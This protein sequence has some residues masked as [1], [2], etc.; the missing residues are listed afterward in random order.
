ML[1]GFETAVA[2]TAA[3]GAIRAVS[4]AKNLLIRTL[5]RRKLRKELDFGSSASQTDNFLSALEPEIAQDLIRFAS[6]PELKNLSMNLATDTLLGHFGKGS[7][8][9]SKELKAQLRTL[10]LLDTQLADPDVDAATEIIFAAMSKAVSAITSEL[11][12]EEDRLPATAK[13][14][15]LKVRDSYLDSAV[16]NSALLSTIRDLSV[17]KNFEDQLKVQ[18]RNLYGTMRLPHAGT[19]RRV[20]YEKLYVP[21]RVSF[22]EEGNATSSIAESKIEVEDLIKH[23]L[24]L[25]LLGDPGGGKSTLS[26]K[27]TFDLASNA[28]EANESAVPFL[29]VLREYASE[30]SKRPLSLIEYLEQTC[31]VFFSIEPPPNAL[32]YL[33]LNGRAFVI[34]DGLDELLDTALRRQVVD[35]VTGFAHRYP[36]TSIL[37]TSRRVGY[38][39]APL[40]PD[41]FAAF[42]LREFD[43]QQVAK[44]VKNWFE[45][46]ES[47]QPGRRKDLCQSF[48]RDSEFVT[49]LR[50]NPLM[51]SLMCGIYA[52][53]NYIPRNRPDVYE[54]CALL[55]FDSWDKQRGIKAPLSFDAHV[56]AAMRSLALWLY[57]QQA[58]QQGLPRAKLINYMKDYLIKKRFDNEEEAENAATEFIDFCKGRA[59]VLTDVG[60]ELYGFTHRTF[61]EYFAASQIVRENTD[62]AR[63]FDYL[64]ERLSGGGWEVVA[65]LALQVLNKS[66]E[67][68][69]DDFLEILLAHTASDI[70]LPL[71]QKLLTFAAQALT[72]IVPRPP[73]LQAMISQAV[74]FYRQRMLTQSDIAYSAPIA[75]SLGASSENLPLVSKYLYDYLE[76][77]LFEDPNDAAPLSLALFTDVYTIQGNPLS[78][79]YSVADNARFWQG[80]VKA[81]ATRFATAIVTQR[82]V[83]GLIAIYLLEHG[84]CSAEEIFSWHGPA[85]IFETVKDAHSR[86]LSLSLAA[87]I[88]LTETRPEPERK[89]INNA[90]EMTGPQIDNLKNALLDLPTPWYTSRGNPD[91]DGLIGFVFDN[92]RPSF[93][94]STSNSAF[95]LFMAAISDITS[96][97]F[98]DARE[99]NPVL[100]TAETSYGHGLATLAQTIRLRAF[101]LHGTSPKSKNLPVGQES[102][103][104]PDNVDFN[105][106]LAAGVDE[107]TA[108]L[109]QRWSTDPKFRLIRVAKR[110][111]KL[112]A[113]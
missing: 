105:M 11:L 43:S 52:S 79:S 95:L 5:N 102:L 54:K 30:M 34:F 99:R 61:L 12:Q 41:M 20:P 56:Q 49:D 85:V 32:E 39:D 104:A 74:D 58:S 64:V 69:A 27:M 97:Q 113:K 67:D 71:K 18:V 21:P 35:A 9:T 7:N 108:A 42:S 26:L 72:Y 90:S 47:V 57:P 78:T 22:L 46:D 15:I 86:R 45:L 91:L 88:L 17:Y 77:L 98:L 10:I 55:L 37:V 2:K 100:S 8:K 89:L 1:T 51:L 23:T 107:R 48:L 59:W 3:S 62:P 96:R 83:N 14:S 68:G 44:Y 103:F 24:R 84:Q 81:N 65:Q 94:R 31:K 16:R 60:A 82:E 63:L 111:T 40:D 50:V 53:E 13:A 87:R 66:V 33:L 73:V 36:T 93:K 112:R 29:V 4:P 28:P 70:G 106:L 75:L 76:R 38:S 92:I 101:L 80:Q 110:L 6:S 19:T 25:I 109:I